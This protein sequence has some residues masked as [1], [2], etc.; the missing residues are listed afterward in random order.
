MAG[1]IG[2]YT[3]RIP[4]SSHCNSFKYPHLYELCL[5]HHS[6]PATSAAMERHFSAAGYIV[7][8]RRSSLADSSLEAM[9][10][11]RCNRDLLDWWSERYSDLRGITFVRYLH[12]CALNNW[13]SH[14][15]VTWW[16]WCMLSLL[17]MNNFCAIFTHCGALQDCCSHNSVT[18]CVLCFLFANWSSKHSIMSMSIVRLILTSQHSN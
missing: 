15:S 12:S 18:W 1:L 9:M 14:C 5:L 4:D 11:A 7:S 8:P 10:M 16:S 13:C 3:R 6:V 17:Q 2:W